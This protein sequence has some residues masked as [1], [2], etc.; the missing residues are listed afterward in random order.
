MALAGGEDEGDGLAMALDAD[1]DFGAEAALAPAEG[2]RCWVPF[3]APPHA[4]GHE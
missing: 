2:L 3:F 1:M 4:G